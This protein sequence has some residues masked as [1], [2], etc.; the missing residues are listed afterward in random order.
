MSHWS[1]GSVRWAQVHCRLPEAAAGADERLE[2]ALAATAGGGGLPA[3]EVDSGPPLRLETDAGQ[4][5]FET[6]GML[7]FGDTGWHL[8]LMP[9]FVAATGDSAEFRPQAMDVT[10]AGPLLTVTQFGSL[11]TGEGT[12][13]VRIDHAFDARDATSRIDCTLHNPAAARHPGGLWDL[14]DEG[15]RRF[16]AF[17]V[18]ITPPIPFDAAELLDLR[19]GRR[20]NL[21]LG[22]P[23]CLHQESSGG[24]N[25]NSSNHCN[26]AGEVTLRYSGYR[27]FAGERVLE[28][29]QRIDPV[30]TLGAQG[31][32]LGVWMA[33]FWQAFPSAFEATTGGLILWTFPRCAEPHELQGGER[34]RTRMHIDWAGGEQRL[35]CRARP[36]LATLAPEVYARARVFTGFSAA[37]RV[38]A[39]ERLVEESGAEGFLAKR[40][41][42]DEYGWRNFGDIFA[43][44]E[45]LYRGEGE[46]P[47]ISHYNNQ[48]DAL[49]GFARRYLRTGDT[50]WYRLMDDLAHHVADIDIYHT[51]EDRPDYNHG[52][53]WHTDH[54]LDARTATHRT[55]SRHNPTSSTEGQTGGGPGD[56]HCYATGLLH[57]YFLTGERT[58]RDAV[59]ELAGW[60]REF[61]EGDGLLRTVAGWRRRELPQLAALLRGDAVLPYR[62]PFTRGTGN[63][64]NVLLDEFELSGECSTL[65]QVADVIRRTLAPDDDI[66]ARRLLDV[67]RCWSYTVL[68]SAIV[69]FIDV[70]VADRLLLAEAGF[71]RDALVHYA[72][73][74]AR[75]ERPYLSRP[76]ILEFPNDTWAA[77]ELRKA[78]VLLAAANMSDTDEPELRARGRWFL[79]LATERLA[80]SPERSF[81]R[82]QVILLQHDALHGV[83]ESSEDYAVLPAPVRRAGSRPAIPAL[84]GSMLRNLAR[85]AWRISPRRELRWVR[86]RLG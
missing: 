2:L 59:L 44:H 75:N 80:D 6:N 34:R 68:L 22:E 52:M 24:E 45:S 14:G 64:I 86:D 51:D 71:A 8:E 81:T 73:W 65:Q 46:P 19:S 38:G 37:P 60:M 61:F 21:G 11:E 25:W 3:P 79:D 78:F 4:F 58:S 83:L 28:S 49:D 7:R 27:L 55:F 40:E 16:A 48:Y 42:I 30:L 18:R 57:H 43:D 72:R 29:G 12:L 20:H 47:F 70:C 50:R 53:F 26:A 41:I 66:E 15:S 33:D 35:C 69:R 32:G 9:V 85:A 67:E 74:M 31:R 82:I 17:G 5:V 13:A 36:L 76:E 1:D 56:E 23:L 62:Y 77:Q 54:Y 84:V 10:R 39:L 63:Y